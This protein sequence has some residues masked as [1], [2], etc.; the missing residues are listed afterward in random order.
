MWLLRCTSLILYQAGSDAVAH[1]A[2]HSLGKDLMAG[3]AKEGKVSENTKYIEVEGIQ[4]ARPQIS[5]W[6]ASG[7]LKINKCETCYTTMIDI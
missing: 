2:H 3:R 7:V 1:C 4:G 6:R 5:I